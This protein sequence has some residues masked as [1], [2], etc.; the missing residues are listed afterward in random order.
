MTWFDSTYKLKDLPETTEQKSKGLILVIAARH[1]KESWVFSRVF[2]LFSMKWQL[3]RQLIS[4]NWGLI[5]KSSLV[6]RRC[7]WNNYGPI[8]VHPLVG[9]SFSRVGSIQRNI[10]SLKLVL[11]LVNGIV[12]S[13][14]VCRIPNSFV[15]TVR[16]LFSLLSL[17]P[18]NTVDGCTLALTPHSVWPKTCSTTW[19]DISMTLTFGTWT[20]CSVQI[21]P[22]AFLE[23]THPK[24]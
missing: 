21:W 1:L 3:T 23:L 15:L 10:T 4:I 12:I 7:N 11:A 18:L 2:H 22:Q 8:T 14:S 13:L 20:L 9:E 5:S 16:T 19:I 6:C 17:S 24:C